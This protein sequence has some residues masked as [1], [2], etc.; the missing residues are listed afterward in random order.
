MMHIN[1][2]HQIH[3]HCTSHDYRFMPSAGR[4]VQR[5]AY[6]GE[7]EAGGPMPNKSQ[8]FNRVMLSFPDLQGWEGTS[9][10]P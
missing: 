7:W 9:K 5:W 4:T 6:T 2:G 1:E 8:I 3:S 10:S